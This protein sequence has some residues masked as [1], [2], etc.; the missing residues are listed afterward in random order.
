MAPVLRA[1]KTNVAWGTGKDWESRTVPETAAKLLWAN[2]A[3]ETARAHS[4][5]HKDRMN[6][7]RKDSRRK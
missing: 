4:N 5:I 7:P 6:Y 2:A 1:L 3:E